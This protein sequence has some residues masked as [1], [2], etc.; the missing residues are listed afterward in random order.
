MPQICQTPPLEGGA[1]RDLL[2][3]WSHPLNIVSDWRA[4]L[5]ASRYSLSPSMARQISLLLFGEGS[6]DC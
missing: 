5:V 1:G 2:G 3:G 4:Q 6:H